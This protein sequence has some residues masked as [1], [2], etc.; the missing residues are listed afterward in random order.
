MTS[1]FS[2][3]SFFVS[4]SLFLKKKKTTLRL[5]DGDFSTSYRFLSP[6]RFQRGV[7]RYE[8]RTENGI[9]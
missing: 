4:F 1:L 7:E 6:L 5:P 9:P 2:S 8:Q 3:V